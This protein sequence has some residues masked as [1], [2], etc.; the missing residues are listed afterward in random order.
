MVESN[1]LHLAQVLS[2]NLMKHNVFQGGDL[3]LRVKEDPA[4]TL[5]KFVVK[6]CWSTPDPSATHG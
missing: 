4:S 5:F 1:S 2:P 3:F 6:D